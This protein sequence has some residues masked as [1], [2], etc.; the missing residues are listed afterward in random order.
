MAEQGVEHHRNRE[1]G[2]S[3]CT[4]ETRDQERGTK[5]RQ[6]RR[7]AYGLLGLFVL[8]AGVL[9]LV[10]APAAEVLQIS[11]TSFVLRCSAGNCPDTGLDAV[12]EEGQGLLLNARGRYFAPAVFPTTG[13]SVC[14]FTLWYRDNDGD[15]DV[16]ARL[17]RKRVAIG[18]NAFTAPVVMAQVSSSGFNNT[19]QRV[20]TGTVS[21]RLV[22]TN[23]FF[24]FVELE[25]PGN[26]IEIVGV[27]IDFR[28]T[29]P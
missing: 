2:T 4:T 6:G 13:V 8:Y 28:P 24:Y 7:R 21:G 22:N 23:R 25:V 14:R 5:Q 18:D 20:A 16:T 26:T 17:L 11:A 19:L 29:C 10:S 15:L 12:G 9:G 3:Y 1:A 27:Q